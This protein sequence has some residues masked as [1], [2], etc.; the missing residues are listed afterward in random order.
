LSPVVEKEDDKKLDNK[1]VLDS[2]D[3]ILTLLDAA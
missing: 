1:V 2:L 3:G